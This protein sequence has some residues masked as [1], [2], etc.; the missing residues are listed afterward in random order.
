MSTQEQTPAVSKPAHVPD[1]LVYDFDYYRDPALLRDA[2]ARII[3]L[4]DRAPPVFWTPRHGG[5]WVVQGHDA[6]YDAQRQTEIFSSEAFPYEHLDAIN[7]QAEAATGRKI[8][9]PLPIT[10]DPPVHTMYRK[11]LQKVFSPKAMNALSDDIRTLARRLIEAVKPDG[12]CEFMSAVAEPLPVQVFLKIF[13]LPLDRQREYRDLLDE[14]MRSI[15]GEPAGVQERSWRLADIMHDVLIERRDHPRDDMISLIW[16]TEF[17]GRPATLYDVQNFCVL[18]FIAGLDTVMNGMGHGIRFLAQHPE[19]QAQLRDKPK[20]A[21]D[22]TEEL[23]RRFTFTVPVRRVAQD[24]EFHGA[25]VRKGEQ[26]LMFLPGADLDSAKFAHPERFDLE[27]EDKVHIAFGAGPH[28]CLGSHLAR[29]ELRILYEEM[30]QRLPEFR[31]DPDHPVTYHGGNVIGP[32]QLY[33][34]WD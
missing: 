33:L 6:V 16:Q 13:G 34:R 32:D 23:L 22:A 11:P 27:R 25:P 8:L 24:A 30:T 19:V 21:M 12:A 7:A 26:A 29:I 17:D 20:L 18:L 15:G 5:Q 9:V 2:H 14:H 10:V 31:L 28:R 3:E 1:H 4:Q